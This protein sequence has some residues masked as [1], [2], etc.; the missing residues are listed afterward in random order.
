MWGSNPGVRSVLLSQAAVAA[1][2]SVAVPST[3]SLF[4][5]DGVRVDDDVGVEVRG[6]TCCG[7]L[8]LRGPIRRWLLLRRGV[9]SPL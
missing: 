8:M 6:G 9:F 2:Y 5:P 3:V 7:L 4:F 1:K